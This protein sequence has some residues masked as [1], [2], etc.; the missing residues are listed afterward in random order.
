MFN[1]IQFR[2]TIVKSTLNDLLMYSP[3][4]EELLVFTC[5]NE[6][7]GGTYIRQVDGP[8]L[9]IYQIE[10]ETYNDIWQNYIKSNASLAMRLFSN[11][12][13]C[14]MP[15][16]ERMIYDL[17]FSTAMARIFYFRIKQSLPAANDIDSIWTYYKTHYNTSKGKALKEA[18][19][20]NYHEFLEH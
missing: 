19:I 10:P 9:G 12:D 18:A 7:K 5:A 1:I 2:E 11:F 16:P 20:K 8:A 17:R 3:E 14:G 13:V 15:H 4:A 6:S